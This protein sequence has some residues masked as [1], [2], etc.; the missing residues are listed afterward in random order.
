MKLRYT[1]SFRKLFLSLALAA[2]FSSVFTQILPPRTP[3]PFNTKQLHCGHSLTAPLFGPSNPGGYCQLIADQLGNTIWDVLGTTVGRAVL[4]GSWLTQHWNDLESWNHLPR[5]DA[6]GNPI[7]GNV[8]DPNCD[9]R[10]QI[11]NWE[12]MVVTENWQGPANFSLNKSDKYLDTFVRHA[13]QNGNNGNGAATMLW[14]N[15]PA[16]DGTT[17]FTDN[18]GSYG[19]TENATTHSAFRQ[20]L[21]FLENQGVGNNG[22][23]VRMQNYANTH[24]PAG[25]PPIYVIP[26][27]RMMARFYDD[28]RAGNVPTI[29]SM[30]QILPDG[31]HPNHIGA[32][33]VSLIHY[34][35]IHGRSPVGLSNQIDALQPPINPALATYIQNMIWDVVTSYPL[36]GI[37]RTTSINSIDDE[38]FAVFPN[39]ANNHLI[40]QSTVT[41]FKAEISNSIGQVVL[42]TTDKTIDISSLDNGV[43]FLSVGNRVQKLIKQ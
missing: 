22:G 34:T 39:P 36:S 32:Y 6:F 13:W 28:M 19:F 25:A 12:L 5:L 24:R 41:D 26:G 33:M 15:W 23:W 4:P 35:C 1:T 37:T 7:N 43:Y 27:N 18:F 38:L 16:L 14:T 2:F 17:Y 40:V 8:Y 30:S 11:R 20:L 42:K 21:D 9:P 10:Y 3:S 29:T 31:A